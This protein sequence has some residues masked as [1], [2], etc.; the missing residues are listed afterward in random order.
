[1]PPIH[2]F[3]IIDNNNDD[4]TTDILYYPDTTYLVVMY[5]LTLTRLTG[6]ESLVKL[7]NMRQKKDSHF[8]C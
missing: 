5:D 3:A 1:M 7:R 2:D 6:L 8:M 4:I